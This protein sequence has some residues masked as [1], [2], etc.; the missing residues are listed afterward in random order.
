MRKP[1]HLPALA[2]AALL[3]FA[4]GLLLGRRRRAQRA[5]AAVAVSRAQAAPARPVSHIA[6][7]DEDEAFIDCPS[8]RR[9]IPAA[10]DV[11]PR[12]GARVP[13]GPAMGDR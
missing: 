7:D 9:Q 10:A 2:G 8:C 1:I 3:A 12:C 6:E 4:G 5:P 13:V 11:C